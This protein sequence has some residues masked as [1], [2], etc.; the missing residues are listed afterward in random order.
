MSAAG[1]TIIL[2][3]CTVDMHGIM[4]VQTVC[5]PPVPGCVCVVYQGE[6]AQLPWREVCVYC[7]S[8]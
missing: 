2:F 6:G 8:G 1:T 5:S 4:H 7:V 3:V